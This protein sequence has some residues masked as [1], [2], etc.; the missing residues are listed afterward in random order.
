MR[1]VAL[2]RARL[3]TD[4][5]FVTVGEVNAVTPGSRRP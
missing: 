2:M 1:M 4:M 3:Y 5:T